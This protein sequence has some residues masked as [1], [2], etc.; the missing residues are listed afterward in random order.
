MISMLF[1][2][3]KNKSKTFILFLLASQI[4]LKKTQSDKQTTLR[5]NK[6]DLHVKKARILNLQAVNYTIDYI[7]FLNFDHLNS[8]KKKEM[9]SMIYKIQILF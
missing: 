3:H 4:N 2:S 5:R 6:V 1:H 8:P 9:S 7:P